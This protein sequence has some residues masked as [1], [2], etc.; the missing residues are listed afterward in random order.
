MKQEALCCASG[1][2][3]LELLE[4]AVVVRDGAVAARMSSRKRNEGKR[5][6]AEASESRWDR[7]SA[8][9][10]NGP[11]QYSTAKSKPNSLLIH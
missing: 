11:G 3:V 4:E 1:L 5:A 8:T 10:F 7:A 9:V 2:S 6:F